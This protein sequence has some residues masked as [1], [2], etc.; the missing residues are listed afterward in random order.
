[1]ARLRDD[2][3][4]MTTQPAIERKPGRS[5]R[6]NL[7]SQRI[8]VSGGRKPQNRYLRRITRKLRALLSINRVGIGARLTPQRDELVKAWAASYFLPMLK[9]GKELSRQ[10][11]ESLVEIPEEESICADN[12]GVRR[13]PRP[14][15]GLRLPRIFAPCKK[16]EHSR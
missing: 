16:F 2:R 7:A 6:F 12:Q 3:S 1:M 4:K 10:D 15:K 11:R 8:S 13:V 5:D 9:E 14:Q